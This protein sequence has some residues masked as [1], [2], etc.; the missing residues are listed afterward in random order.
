MPYVHRRVEAGR[1]AEHKKMYSSRVHTK[2]VK[3]KPHSG[4]TSEKQERINERVAEEKLRWKLNANFDY[5]DYHTVFHYWNK[6]I[7]LEQ[8]ERDRAALLKELRKVYATAG[9]KLKYIAV[10]ETKHMTNINHH[11][12][13]NHIDPQLIAQAWEQVTGGN[14][15]VSFKMLDK[16]GNH[17]KL[18]SYLVKE[19]RSTMARYRE[20]GKKHKRYTAST[21]LVPPKIIYEIVQ[22]ASWRKDPKP[23][24]GAQLYMFD[25]G[26]FC[27][28]GWQDTTG[29]P[30]QEYFEV[31]NE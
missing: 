2:G 13:L 23:R 10:T 9:K 7:T 11:I 15:S 17:Y 5:G 28:S 4:A 25:D 14:G 27:R 20:M 21:N 29:W 16:R 22:A 6:R 3:R 19:S 24:K 18:A 31:F 1:T 26:S 12:V 30:Y 8:A